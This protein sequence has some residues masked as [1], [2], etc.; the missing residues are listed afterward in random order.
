MLRCQ[1]F[2]DCL[3]TGADGREDQREHG[4]PR[5]VV[6]IERAAADKETECREECRE[7]RSNAAQEITLHEF[8]V[9]E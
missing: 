8:G 4:R 9:S 3:E 7:E 5:D 2:D 6:E 1:A